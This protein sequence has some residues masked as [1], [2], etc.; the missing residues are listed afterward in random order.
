MPISKNE[1]DSGVSQ[2]PEQLAR[3]Q[4]SGEL[5]Q[6]IVKVKN[7]VKEYG[8]YAQRKFFVVLERKGPA[9]TKNELKMMFHDAH[10]N[11]IDAGDR[12]EV[13]TIIQGEW[14]KV[15]KY[16]TV[17]VLEAQ[18]VDTSPQ[19]FDFNAAYVTSLKVD[20]DGSLFRW[21]PHP[22]LCTDTE[23]EWVK[24]PEKIIHLYLWPHLE[25][26]SK[27][28]CDVDISYHTRGSFSKWKV[29]GKKSGKRLTVTEVLDIEPVTTLQEFEVPL[30]EIF[31][32]PDA[33][34]IDT[35]QFSV[36]V[37]DLPFESSFVFETLKH[38]F[39]GVV[40]V[41]GV[42]RKSGKWDA[43]AQKVVEWWIPDN[44]QSIKAKF[45]GD[46]EQ[47]RKVYADW[48]EAQ[49]YLELL[50]E[51][52]LRPMWNLKEAKDIHRKAG[53]SVDAEDIISKFWKRFYDRNFYDFLRE[54]AKDEEN[55][56]M[57]DN[58]F[59][60][61]INKRIV[62]ERPEYGAATYIFAD[63]DIEALVVKF[64]VTKKLEIIREE[65]IQQEM[66][67]K[68]RALHDDFDMWRYG[69]KNF[70]GLGW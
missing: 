70:C 35:D 63:Q 34:R 50:E 41:T 14:A 52:R 48:V 44:A 29:V 7:P 9:E 24:V 42:F 51:L 36:V 69:V 21:V 38:K 30:S 40:R 15:Y 54:L 20:D 60:F 37:R 16:H 32:L 18:A 3:G 66:K 2:H 25:G 6:G 19:P 67:F 31:Y 68:G 56:F 58:Y 10:Y 43:A 26:E 4:K 23:V 53:I 55:V 49:D 61:R 5:I 11:T 33:V 1:F 27:E 22:P 65:T 57:T 28:Y 62:I 12:I 13:E 45:F 64:E 46:I 39:E 59:I 47:I 17:R 8:Q